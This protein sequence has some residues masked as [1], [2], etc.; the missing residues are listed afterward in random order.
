[1][2]IFLLVTGAAEWLAFALRIPPPGSAFFVQIAIFALPLLF[3]AMDGG[4][5]RSLGLAGSFRLRDLS[6]VV[7]L[8]L[9]HLVGSTLT[10]FYLTLS[11]ALDS[12][13][14]PATG[15]LDSFGTF[16]LG[17]FLLIWVG[18]VFLSGMGEEMLFRGYLI[19]RLERQG[20]SATA[21]VLVSALLFGLVHWP[22]Y[23]LW[24]SLSKAFWFG[25][26]AGLYFSRRRSLWPL[27]AMHMVVN[28]VGFGLLYAAQRLAG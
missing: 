14:L 10:S 17:P 5:I 9:L 26:P 24:L 7:G 15:V 22:G 20:F 8:V 12:G 23:G 13:T 1:M 21:S 27:V 25:I 6:I 16:A 19:T 28:G 2:V 4:G 18:L 3:A 11:G